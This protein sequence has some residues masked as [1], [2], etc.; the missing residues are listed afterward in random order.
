M[1][2]NFWDAYYNINKN[3]K[4]IENASSYGSFGIKVTYKA[5]EAY[6]SAVQFSDTA[7]EVFPHIIGESLY[8]II[9]SIIH[10][11]V[12]G[13][14]EFIP[15]Y[16]RDY[17]FYES[18]CKAMSKAIIDNSKFQIKIDDKNYY[19]I[20]SKKYFENLANVLVEQTKKLLDASNQLI[21]SGNNSS[22]SSSSSS[23]SNR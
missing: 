20:D 4:D 16:K 6:N 17:V 1:I 19:T 23:S 7:K 2:L 5:A 18:L 11:K 12:D 3:I 13:I 8:N 21:S 9:Y 22:S 15:D 14:T 10:K